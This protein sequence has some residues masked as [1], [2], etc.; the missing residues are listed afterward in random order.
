[1][2]KK[3]FNYFTFCTKEKKN[4]TEPEKYFCGV[5]HR[6]GYKYASNMFI[7]IRNKSEYDKTLEGQCLLK[8]GQILPNIEKYRRINFD[9]IIIEDNK[10]KKEYIPIKID[11]DKINEIEK[12]Y[13]YEQQKLSKID[14]NDT[15]NTIKFYS[16]YVISF[17]NRAYINL[18]EFLKFSKAMKYYNIDTLYIHKTENVKPL[19]CANENTNL[20]IM[21]F[22]ID[23]ER[24]DIKIYKCN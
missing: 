6:N 7:F 23:T 4:L 5:H 12:L 15:D 1:M 8:N 16:L 21:P 19:W 24:D 10:R 14:K 11:F 22:D 20:I 17:E 3:E 9:N 2:T 13:K 18:L